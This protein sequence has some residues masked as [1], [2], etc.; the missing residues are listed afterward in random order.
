MAPEMVVIPPS[1]VEGVQQAISREFQKYW[2]R[3]QLTEPSP[4]LR[5]PQL[6]A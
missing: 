2:R 5:D 6:S 4:S 1:N 3:P